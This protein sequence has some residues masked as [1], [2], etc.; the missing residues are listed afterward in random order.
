[1]LNTIFNISQNKQTYEQTYEQIQYTQINTFNDV[2]I[3]LNT[4]VICDIDETALYFDR[5]YDKYYKMMK[6]DHPDF[7]EEEIQ[8]L[9]KG[10]YD[11]S[12]MILP[13]LSTD[14]E[15]FKKMLEIIKQTNSEL[16]FLT[17]RDKS[18]DK[19]TKKDLMTSNNIKYNMENP[20]RNKLI[21]KPLAEPLA[22]P[23][24]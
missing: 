18:S 12:V 17:A 8:D 4:L 13:A 16:I 9:A 5:S 1:M 15:G 11:L 2:E 6:N 3:K 14:V 21:T 10:M 20:L 19:K 7:P 22:E 23:L 24:A